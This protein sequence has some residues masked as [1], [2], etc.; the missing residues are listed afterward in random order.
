MVIDDL[1]D[2]LHDC[3]LLLDQNLGRT[4]RDYEVGLLKAP[5]TVLVGPQYALL[6]PEFVA[7]R[8]HSLARRYGAPFRQILISMGGVDKD[9]VTGTVLDALRTHLL[10][11]N[12]EIEVVMGPHAPHLV[13]VR[14]R[15]ASMPWS[16]Q[17]SVNVADMAKRLSECDLTIGAAGST[18]WERCS[19]GVP[20]LLV[21]VA[22]NQRMVIAALESV[23]AAVQI[24]QAALAQS[25]GVVFHRQFARLTNN[26]Q[27]YAAAAA[28]VTD[29]RGTERVCTQLL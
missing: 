5:C 14:K 4:V 23:G 26:L 25:D 19:L 24:D 22:D 20:S 2:R 3:D 7:L 16:T 21:C 13:E 1:A 10:P 8:P 12:C 29:G 27:E 11:A 15:A 9:N 6:R 18:S 17:V 28:R